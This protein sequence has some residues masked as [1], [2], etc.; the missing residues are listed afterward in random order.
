MLGPGHG[1]H[2]EEQEH[3]DYTAQGIDVVPAR[4]GDNEYNEHGEAHE[5]ETRTARRRGEAERDTAVEQVLPDLVNPLGEDNWQV[6]DR[7]QDPAGYTDGPVF[8]E[9]PLTPDKLA[10]PAARYAPTEGNP[11]PGKKPPQHTLIPAAAQQ[12][13]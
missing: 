13:P 4:M 12:G 11:N 7:R 3:Q 6:D 10:E 1:P 5:E 9:G 8:W 2:P